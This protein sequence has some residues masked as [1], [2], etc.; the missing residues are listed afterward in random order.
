LNPKSEFAQQ[1][2]G[3]ER[4]TSSTGALVRSKG[5]PVTWPRYTNAALAAFTVV[6][7]LSVLRLVHDGSSLS[8][9]SGTGSL[10]QFRR[11][12]VIWGPFAV[13]AVLALGMVALVS[14]RRRMMQT[15]VRRAQQKVFVS[16]SWSEIEQLVPEF[17]IQ[18]GFGVSD[19]RA[20][21]HDDALSA[22]L[23]CGRRYLLLRCHWRYEAPV[24]GPTIG[25]VYR[26]M[27]STG[28]TGAY[29][30]ASGGFTRAAEE[31]AAGRPIVLMNSSRLIEKMRIAGA[32]ARASAWPQEDID[33][34]GL[35]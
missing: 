32:V 23:R 34:V 11:P 26:V 16:T 4:T 18:Q 3:D 17:F 10:E 35:E 27:D 14:R 22:E 2:G 1:P 30:L 6:I 8:E 12:V 19:A 20:V 21:G 9:G 5:A 24:D 31:F 7:F 25:Q 29:V 33:P 15:G 28:A 13:L